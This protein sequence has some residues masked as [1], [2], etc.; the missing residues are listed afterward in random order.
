[1]E[2]SESSGVEW[3]KHPMVQLAYLALY[4]VCSLRFLMVDAWWVISGNLFETA[5]DAPPAAAFTLCAI[6][7]SF[8]MKSHLTRRSSGKQNRYKPCM[9]FPS[10]M[11]CWLFPN[12]GWPTNLFVFLFSPNI[13]SSLHSKIEYA[14]KC[15]LA[16]EKILFPIFGDKLVIHCCG[17]Q[18]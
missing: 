3:E 18:Q 9:G 16:S 1:M 14:E 13:Y 2:R 7:L 8:I 10:H 11:G 17:K 4:K 12:L 5:A 6:L 15:Y